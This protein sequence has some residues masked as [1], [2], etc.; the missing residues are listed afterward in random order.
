MIG[1]WRWEILCSKLHWI[2]NLQVMLSFQCAE[3]VNEGELLM[4]WSEHLIDSMPRFKSSH[5]RTPVEL[6]PK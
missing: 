5:T 3:F 2:M 1:W 4:S 6:Y